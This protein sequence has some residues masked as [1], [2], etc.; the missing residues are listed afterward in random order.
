M[1]LYGH[2]G[3]AYGDMRSHRVISI[4]MTHLEGI[5]VLN[6]TLDGIVKVTAGMR[7][8]ALDVLPLIDQQGEY[9]ID[10]S[11]LKLYLFPPD[12]GISNRDFFLSLVHPSSKSSGLVEI[13]NVP[14][15]RL[16][17]LTI[18]AASEGLLV[19]N[20]SV[21]L[22][23]TDCV[24]SG[25]GTNCMSATDLAHSSI[26]NITIAHC[27]GT[28]LTLS[29]GTWYP[30]DDGD[31]SPYTTP[32]LPADLWISANVSLLNSFL[33]DWARWQRIPNHPALVWTGV[34]HSV[35][36]CQ[37]EMGPSPAVINQGS[38]DFTFEANMISSCPY[39]YNDMG[40]YYHGGSAGG[41][42][43]GWTQ[44]GNVIVGNLWRHIKFVEQRPSTDDYNF[45][46][47]GLT[48]QAIYL[49]DG[50]SGYIVKD[51][52]FE[53]IE[54]GIVLG[55]GRRHTVFNNSFM[56]CGRACI[57]VDN[58][59]MNWAHELCGCQCSFGTCAPGCTPSAEMG[60]G[61]N[62]STWT[63]TNTTCAPGVH[64]CPPFRFQQG[65]R[66]LRCAGI[67]AA[68]PCTVRIPWL[69]TLLDDNTG[70]GPCAPAHN[71]VTNNSFDSKS[72]PTPWQFC[73]FV[74]NASD[75]T[76]ECSLHSSVNLPLYS[77]WGSYA[78]GN[79]YY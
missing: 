42:Q 14:H 43:Y 36:G 27:G 39:E 40:A 76:R 56:M 28:G 66:K 69:K 18:A 72:C 57:H 21:G 23:V 50:H 13:R 71:R 74:K 22:E 54:M 44:T 30:G 32:T 41:Y 16:I 77:A 67:H 46:L 6:I 53:D 4:A 24:L 62:K 75:F 68:P 3:D 79:K 17:N 64:G 7:F 10:R 25:A 26:Q 63:V 60:Q 52:S 1:S 12:G 9:W 38:M 8:V 78:Q 59:G 29:G 11:A 61:L 33:H 35:R 48:T 73:G 5:A 19:V 58:R 65:A 2:W 45:T 20:G 70:G 37:F 55:G 51:N 47:N 49:D 15:I 31:A 34:G